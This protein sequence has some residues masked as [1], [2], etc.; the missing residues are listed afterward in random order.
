[1]YF[2]GILPADDLQQTVSDLKHHFAREY[3]SSHALKSPPH[4]TLI[5]PFHA[6]SDQLSLVEDL[7]RAKTSKLE[8]FKVQL[9]GFGA[10]K[11]RVIFIRPKLPSSFAFDRNDLLDDFYQLFPDERRDNRPF[12]PH[13]TIAFKDLTPAMFKRAWAEFENKSF[14]IEFTASSLF[15]LKYTL[16]RWLVISEFPFRK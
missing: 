4:I 14:Y 13:M 12:H 10:F 9:H 15:M 11:P 5:P 2:L 1:M 7:V 6:N 16:G 3:H 8:P